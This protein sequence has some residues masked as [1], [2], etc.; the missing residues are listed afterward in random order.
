MD[1]TAVQPPG[2]IV[3]NESANLT[4]LFADVAGSTRLYERCGDK[5]ALRRVGECLAVAT[6]ATHANGGEVVK[7]IG[8]ELMCLFPNS[9]SATLAA[10]AMQS[11]VH[12]L[13]QAGDAPMSLR[14]GFQS[15]P[16]LRREGDVFGDTVNVAAR[17]VGMA[18]AGQILLGDTAS[19]TLPSY[20]RFGLRA[21]GHAAVRGRATEVRLHEIVWDLAA[22]L[23]MVG[24]TVALKSMPAPPVLELRMG[25]LDWRVERGAITIGRDAANQVVL[26]TKR[27]SR[28]H[29]RIESRD[30]RFILCDLS[31]NGTWM[32]N[33]SGEVTRLCGDEAT[34]SGSGTLTFGDRPDV[35]GCV[36]MRYTVG[37]GTDAR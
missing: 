24:G 30:G 17:I 21:L 32:T 8:D 14:I 28:S 10:C 16:V 4:V 37:N 18:A 3:V 12:G 2:T 26:A 5:E 22:D 1:D 36:E 35:E 9:G 23:T 31:A 7:T 19:E 29:A 6:E 33:G 25:T 11:G 34:L 20:L 15:G 27:A 13:P